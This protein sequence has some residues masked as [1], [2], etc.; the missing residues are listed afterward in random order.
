M[1][2]YN[3]KRC[4][5]YLTSYNLFKGMV[6]FCKSIIASYG[7]LKSCL[8]DLC[9]KMLPANEIMAPLAFTAS[10]MIFVQYNSHILFVGLQCGF[11]ELSSPLLRNGENQEKK[12]MWQ[13][14]RHEYVRSLATDQSKFSSCLQEVLL[15]SSS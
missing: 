6:F 5:K 11:I 9:Q 2:K 13:E 14:Y 1:K 4:Y 15:F 3:L 7:H 10:E 8:L 12:K